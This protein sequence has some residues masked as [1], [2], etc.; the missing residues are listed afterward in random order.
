MDGRSWC[1][2]VTV[3]GLFRSQL[4][5]TPPKFGRLGWVDSVRGL[6]IVLMVLDHV[7][8]QVDPHSS[9]RA[10][11]PWSITRL[12][13]PLFMLAAGQVWR[14]SS[15][16]HLNRVKLL[17]VGLVEVLLLQLLGM[18]LPGIVLIIWMVFLWLDLFAAVLDRIRYACI[19]AWFWPLGV[20][21]LLQALYVPVDWAGYQ[22]GLVL[23]WWALGFAAFEA[24]WTDALDF[25]ALR[26]I[27]RYPLTW[28]VGHL[29]VI[30]L[31][32]A[33]GELAV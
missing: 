28:Y 32:V 11:A 8:V 27:G 6:A 2:V 16:W 33:G 31:V 22:P 1:S 26:W 23:L 14:P 3:V 13:L 10:G 15:P 21:G 9:L 5:A 29:V 12:S 20:G 18:Q 17:G 7:L 19:E 24:S 4:P 30:A 25:R